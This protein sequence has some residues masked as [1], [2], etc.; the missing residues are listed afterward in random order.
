MSSP[1]RSKPANAQTAELPTAGGHTPVMLR[2]VV[3]LLEPSDGAIYVDGTFGAGGY[4]TA[5]LEAADCTVWGIDRD[6]TAVARG[7]TLSQRFRGRLEVIEGCYG[8]MDKLLGDHGVTAV[9]GIALDLGL[10]SIQLDD[11]ARGFSFRADGPLDMRM[12]AAPAGAHSG[13]SRER[14]GSAPASAIVN[15]L[16][17]DE[18]ARI[19]RRYG[20]ERRARQVARA[21]VV[22]RRETPIEK[23]TQLAAI[24]RKVVRPSRDGIDPATRT[25]QALRIYV[26][27]ELGELTRGLQAAERLLAPGGRLAVVSFHSLEDRAVKNFLRQRCGTAAR[28]S[29]HLPD[30]A[31]AR[32]EPSFHLLFK[33]TRKPSA[34]ET[35]DN[36]RAR[37]ARLR[38]AERAAAAPFAA[39]SPSPSDPRAH[40]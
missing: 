26:N 22:A 23:T 40:S 11:P 24:I 7:A 12:S 19:I 28:P 20:E 6:P 34:R 35:A 1:D 10:S 14:P 4:T 13:T 3:E 36:P 31:G 18:L 33:G 32:V 30:P 15:S 17:E 8:D 38:G 16:E 29:R 27:D 9:Q 21:I 25:F 5:L 37:S 39:S 2:E